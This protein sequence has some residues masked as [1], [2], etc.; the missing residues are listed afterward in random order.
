MKKIILILTFLLF[1]ICSF[2][3]DV[4]TAKT[5]EL[6]EN[7]YGRSVGV[8]GSELITIWYTGSYAGT[9][10]VSGTTAA[11]GGLDLF[12]YEDGVALGTR[13]GDYASISLYD[14]VYGSTTTGTVQ[15]VVDMINSDTSEVFKAA[16]GRDATPGSVTSYILPFG[17]KSLST[18][19]D[20]A[21]NEG[22]VVKEDT[23]FSKE[24]SAGF[25]AKDN[26]I[27]RLKSIRHNVKG[28]DTGIVA[29]QTTTMKI[30]DNKTVI[31][32][33]DWLPSAYETATASTIA[34]RDYGDKGLSAHEGNCL[35]VEIFNTTD[36]TGSTDGDSNIS[37]VAGEWEE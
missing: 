26:V 19:Q 33:A 29:N 9:F 28:S 34:F 3:G 37:L 16:V 24:L 25:R 10:G 18:S 27:H 17:Q 11:S 12:L 7:P 31:W 20:D 35:V 1:S 15:L 36:V 8:D 6:Y 14:E 22:S 21:I 2:A 30:W 23:S 4:D 5:A 32:R 13:F